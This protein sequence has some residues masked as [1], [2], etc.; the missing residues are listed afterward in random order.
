MKKLK[1]VQLFENFQNLKLNTDGSL[2]GID[3]EPQDWGK[4][5]RYVFSKKDQQSYLQ[6]LKLASIE[7]GIELRD[8]AM[9]NFIFLPNETA[10]KGLP[11]VT[12]YTNKSS[13]KEFIEWFIGQEWHNGIYYGKSKDSKPLAQFIGSMNI[14]NTNVQRIE[15]MILEQCPI[16]KAEGI[17]SEDEFQDWISK[18][19][20]Q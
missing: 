14:K 19:T 10:I 12:F 18:F 16:L 4:F 7:S 6:F 2:D 9:L 5:K 3:I 8:T 13:G 11:Y 20:R 15:N 17:S 1:Y